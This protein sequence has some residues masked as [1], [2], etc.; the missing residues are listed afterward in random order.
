VAGLPARYRSLGVF[1]NI[2]YVITPCVGGYL[3]VNGVLRFALP[4]LTSNL[5]VPE[6][7][8]RIEQV[9]HSGLFLLDVLYLINGHKL[10]LL[11]YER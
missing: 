1:Q 2:E 3:C 7:M 4:M 8:L 11:A 6:I 10:A 5:N 9:R